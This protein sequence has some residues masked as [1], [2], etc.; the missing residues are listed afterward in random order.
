MH[1]PTGAFALHVTDKYMLLGYNGQYLKCT[2]TLTCQNSE[3]GLCRCLVLAQ[4]Y[5]QLFASCLAVFIIAEV[6]SIHLNGVA[7]LK[8]TN[9]VVAHAGC[10]QAELLIRQ[11][12]QFSMQRKHLIAV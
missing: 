4:L 9:H 8:L 6:T 11:S 5:C 10:R 1:T 2:V 3:G 7:D 12:R